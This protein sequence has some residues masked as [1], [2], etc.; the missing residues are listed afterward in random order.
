MFF[1]CCFRCERD[2]DHENSCELSFSNL[3]TSPVPGNSF[4]LSDISGEVKPGEI[5]AV[6]GVSTLFNFICGFSSNK[7]C[8]QFAHSCSCFMIKKS[9]WAE[10]PSRLRERIS[11][12]LM[13]MYKNRMFFYP[14]RNPTKKC[15]S[16]LLKYGID[17]K[18][19]WKF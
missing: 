18:P 9:N 16:N 14:Y 15:K 2:R 1:S 11:N 17:N 19:P 10:K 13:H 5:L 8:L 6:M 12:A 4:V 7:V 3:R